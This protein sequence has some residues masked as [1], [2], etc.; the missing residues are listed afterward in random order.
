MVKEFDA[1]GAYVGDF[2]TGLQL[3]EG[4][5]MDTDGAILIGNGGTGAVLRFN[6]EGRSL[7]ALF[8]AGSAGLMTPNAITIRRVNF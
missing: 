4:I 1:E 8:P 7:G 5:A 6:S 2:I 3:P